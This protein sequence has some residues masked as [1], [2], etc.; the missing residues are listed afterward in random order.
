MRLQKK[1]QTANSEYVD[2]PRHAHSQILRFFLAN[3]YMAQATW[4]VIRHDR[5]TFASSRTLWRTKGSLLLLGSL[6]WLAGLGSA[7]WQSGHLEPHFLFI[8]TLLLPPIPEY[9]QEIPFNL[10]FRSNLVAVI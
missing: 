7:N 6:V 5:P 4:T 8:N 9:T 3:L 1:R 2:S 10:I